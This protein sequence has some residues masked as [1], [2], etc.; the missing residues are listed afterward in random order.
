MISFLR[1]LAPT[2]DL[3]PD[4]IEKRLR[5]RVTRGEFAG[6]SLAVCFMLGLLYLDPTGSGIAGDFRGHMA[7]GHGDLTYFFYPNWFIPFYAGLAALPFPVAYCTINLINLV[8]IWFAC[9]V[10]NGNGA[11]ALSSYQTLH[12]MYYGQTTGI[13]LGGLALM[14]W[15]MER[16][17]YWLAGAALV[18]ALIKYQTGIPLILALWLTDISP[19][20]EKLRIAVIPIAVMVVS[21]LVYGLW[22]ID[23]IHRLQNA[24]PVAVNNVVLWQWI[25]PLVLVLWLP[26]I[27]LP[28]SRNRRI[29]AVAA[30]TALAIPYLLHN[31]LLLLFML[32]VGGLGLLG[33][34]GYLKGFPQFDWNAL[35]AL[36]FIPLLLY[37]WVFIDHFKSRA[38]VSISPASVQESDSPV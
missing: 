17:R 24:P 30:T 6:F 9:R 28:L 20:R 16:K 14:Y 25:G 11:I 18:I 33:N 36:V 22:P 5:V 38:N 3:K 26:V 21:L 2:F 10:F 29:I 23:L 34:F 4:L 15:A 1:R 13:L 32:P 19:F 7:A 31:D 37:V 35:R 12:V 27:F 8:G